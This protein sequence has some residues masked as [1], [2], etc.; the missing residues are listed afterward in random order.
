MEVDINILQTLKV[1]D[2][3]PAYQYPWLAELKDRIQKLTTNRK[4]GEIYAQRLIEWGKASESSP[5]R[6]TSEP[7]PGEDQLADHH[8]SLGSVS[9]VGRMWIPGRYGTHRGTSTEVC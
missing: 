6:Y 8:A 3:L 1:R 9:L 2:L 4:D 7:Q 5:Q